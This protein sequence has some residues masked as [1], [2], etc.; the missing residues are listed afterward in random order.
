MTVDIREL[1][2]CD[3]ATPDGRE[4]GR[5]LTTSLADR[6]RN[7]MATD[8]SIRLPRERKVRYFFAHPK[9]VA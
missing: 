9:A 4:P 7:D 1:V 6:S 8:H 3:Q 5:R 2:W